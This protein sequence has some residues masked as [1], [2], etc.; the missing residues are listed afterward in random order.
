MLKIAPS[1]QPWRGSLLPTAASRP[2]S[3]SP[4]SHEYHGTVCDQGGIPLDLPT[5]GS[6]LIL[7]SS[8]LVPPFL[9]SDVQGSELVQNGAGDFWMNRDQDA[10]ALDAACEKQAGSGRGRVADRPG[11]GGGTARDH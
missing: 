10:L 7:R 4:P 1:G 5:S 9:E 6:G 3:P 11:N 8:A 2:A